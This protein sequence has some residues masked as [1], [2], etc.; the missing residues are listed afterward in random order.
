MFTWSRRPGLLVRLLLRRQRR[1]V[2]TRGSPSVHASSRLRERGSERIVPQTFTD[3]TELVNFEGGFAPLTLAE[4]SY[5]SGVKKCPTELKF[6]S[7]AF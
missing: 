2:G 5:R 3:Q 7:P 4:G 6:I 1:N